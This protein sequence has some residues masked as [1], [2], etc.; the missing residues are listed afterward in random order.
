MKESEFIE[1]LNLYLDHEISAADAARLEAEVQANPA[2]RRVYQQYCRMQKACKIVVADFQAEAARA[3]ADRKVVPFEPAA[4]AAA[5]GQRARMNRFYTVGTFAAMAACVAI[6]F[7][8]R[9]RQQ[10]TSPGTAAPADNVARAVQPTTPNPTND[11]AKP[12]MVA[13][14]T[15]TP[16]GLV[17]VPR[18]QPLNNHPLLLSGNSQ[19]EAIF[20]G[21]QQSQADT[22]LD[23]INALHLA[24]LPQRVAADQFHFDAHPTSLR[25]ENG[26]ALGGRSA[27]PMKNLG[28]EEPKEYMGFGFTR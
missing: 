19:T 13:T 5:V 9:S 21:T 27:S 10:Q 17:V 7:V 2:R 25:P 20:T 16:R 1:L 18:A 11:E 28:A 3:D 12:T 22:Q 26:R 4:V 8:G 6:I 15:A 23:W 24:P 14:D